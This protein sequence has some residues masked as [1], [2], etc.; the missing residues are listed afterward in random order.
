MRNRRPSPRV[1]S[2]VLLG[3]GNEEEKSGIKGDIEV[4]DS[5]LGCASLAV[6]GP[7]KV[8]P[9]RSP[10]KGGR[11]FFGGEVRREDVDTA[12]SCSPTTVA[13]I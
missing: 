12:L 9:T 6:R 4:E 7:S 1:G 13:V 5:T 11:K 8:R 3:W 2:G 10:T